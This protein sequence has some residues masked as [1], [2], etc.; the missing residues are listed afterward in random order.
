ME[1]YYSMS[2]T[3]FAYL[4]SI[5]DNTGGTKAD[6]TAHKR[7]A[8]TAFSSLNKIWHSTQTKFRI[9]NTK[10][11]AVILYGCETWKN[12]K[13]ITAKLQIFINKCLKENIENFLAGPDYE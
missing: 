2:V 6:I 8:Q 13:S 1:L 12:S 11:K 9:F 7:K 10:V 4:G 5:I 3:Q